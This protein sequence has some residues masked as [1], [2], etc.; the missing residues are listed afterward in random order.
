VRAQ[1]AEPQEKHV[2]DGERHLGAVKLLLAAGAS[3][4][5]KDSKGLTPRE[6]AEDS[7]HEKVAALLKEYEASHG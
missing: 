3:T 6:A 4:H 7:K 2:L 1:Y 5:A